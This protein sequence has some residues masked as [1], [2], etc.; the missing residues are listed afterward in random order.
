MP[1]FTLYV[2]AQSVCV[3]LPVMNL[4]VNVNPTSSLVHRRRSNNLTNGAVTVNLSHNLV[5]SARH[6][7]YGFIKDGADEDNATI[8]VLKLY[9]YKL[10]FACLVNGK[11][12]DPL[13]VARLCR[14]IMECGLVHFAYRSDRE[15]AIVSLI[16]DAC[17]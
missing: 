9:P 5:P 11:G 10:V 14:F 1:C 13:A 12:S 4:P 17:A 7:N 2:F 16:Q 8:L 6:I 15:P 3:S